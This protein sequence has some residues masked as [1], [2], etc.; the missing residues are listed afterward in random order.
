MADTVRYLMEA[1]LPELEDLARKGYFTRDEVRAIAKR[2]ESFEY[3]LKRRAP[4]KADYLRY[5]EYE[6]ALDTLR[7][8]RRAALLS[9]VAVELR[10]VRAAAGDDDKK[11]RKNKGGDDDAAEEQQEEEDG[12]DGDV[13]KP[14]KLSKAAAKRR[15][16]ELRA[17]RDALRRESA[18]DHGARRRVHFVYE[19]AT[20]RFRRDASLWS[21]WLD[22]CRE[23]RSGRRLSRVAAKALRAMPHEP[24]FWV[25]AAAWELDGAADPHAARALMQRGLRECRRDQRAAAR[26]WEAYAGMEAAYVA[27]MRA[28]REVLGLSVPGEEDEEEEKG[29]HEAEDRAAVEAATKGAAAREAERAAAEA[30]ARKSRKRRMPRDGEEDGEEEDEEDT[31]SSSEEQEDDLSEEDDDEE[32]EE[33]KR[34]RGDKAAAAAPLSAAERSKAGDDKAA[35]DAVLR[36][37]VVRAVVRAAARALPHD[38]GLRLRLAALLDGT[39][40]VEGGA[41][42]SSPPFPGA[43]RIADELWLGVAADFPT[44]AEAWDARARRA[45]ALAARKAA[46][47]GEK[48]EGEAAGERA[49]AA[50]YEEGV[51]ALREASS[52]ASSSERRAA[53]GALWAAYCA[54]LRERLDAA[55]ARVAKAA[56]AA[57]EE[58]EEQQQPKRGRGAPSAAA[59]KQKKQEQQRRA[60]ERDA[61]A[62][63]AARRAAALFKA[64]ARA[65]AAVEEQQEEEQRGSGGEPAW[66][67][68]PSFYARTWA[69]GAR[70]AGQLAVA[71]RA[72]RLGAER[73]HPGSA[74]AWLALLELKQQQEEQEEA[75]LLG[76]A[77]EAVG[78]P[79]G[80]AA[81]AEREDDDNDDSDSDDESAALLRLW[82]R[83]GRE[84]PPRAAAAAFARLWSSRARR[85]EAAAGSAAG[86]VAERLLEALWRRSSG[87]R[88]AARE[89]YARLRLLPPPGGELF[90]AMAR[91]EMEEEEREE[92][93]AAAPASSRVQRARTALED[94]AAAYGDRDVQ[95]WLQY[96]ALAERAGGGGGA[97]TASAAGSGPVDVAAMTAARGRKQGKSSGQQQAQGGAAAASAPT[98]G[99]VHFRAVRALGAGPRPELA[100]EFAAA[101]A[102]RARA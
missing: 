16:A 95:L 21:S 35:A 58:D 41:S 37:A 38:L 87:G 42:S 85:A 27:R 15:M 2:R 9:R 100:D 8:H 97:E 61:T 6:R 94:G 25:A 84:L 90:R 99:G 48:A 80:L 83:A 86:A 91:L 22:Y 17:E 23:T 66:P 70:A 96:V 13:N 51:A 26:M 50:V 60:Q 30:A 31:M 36:G 77:L 33:G 55:L 81:S 4:V 68:P 69:S 32:G 53:A 3:A 20:R 63:A 57:A 7:A 43:T 92:G 12:N 88:A 29:E 34:Q 24:G 56:A 78:L 54:F 39:A 79:S 98:V 40:G 18:A 74:C 59:A 73:R 52:S 62:L 71:E 101:W 67:L 89:L 44:R 65:D 45:F 93:A 64:C 10:A 72:A 28:R 47:S 1:M 19:R 75:G 11:S 102:A 46:G 14:P 76:R 5:A 49:A 82:S